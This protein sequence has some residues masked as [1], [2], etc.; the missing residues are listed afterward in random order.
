MVSQTISNKLV[1]ILTR[2]ISTLYDKGTFLGSRKAPQVQPFSRARFNTMYYN[3][4]AIS[5]IQ[6]ISKIMVSIVNSKILRNL[7]TNR[8]ERQ[9]GFFHERWTVDSAFD[10]KSPAV[11]TDEYWISFVCIPCQYTFEYPWPDASYFEI[12]P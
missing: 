11:P 4:T 3:D 5:L 7:E 6:I 9:T 10:R 1:P 8:D 2:F 12:N